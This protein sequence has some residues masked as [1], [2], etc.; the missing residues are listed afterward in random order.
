MRENESDLNGGGGVWKS[1]KWEGR[2]GNSNVR[3]PLVVT[4]SVL[5]QETALRLACFFDYYFFR[6][7]GTDTPHFALTC[8]GSCVFWKISRC[9][10]FGLFPLSAASA[11]LST[12]SCTSLSKFLASALNLNLANVICNPSQVYWVVWSDV[13]M[14]I[15]RCL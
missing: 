6:S 10:Y 3:R 5:V 4:S 7:N 1:A 8:Y 12:H 9:Y 15:L 14:N 11:R 2:R 13:V